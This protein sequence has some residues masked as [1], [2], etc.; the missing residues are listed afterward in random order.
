MSQ[1]YRVREG[2]VVQS[3]SGA[4]HTSGKVFVP[5]HGELEGQGHALEAVD[6]PCAD[7]PVLNMPS[8]TGRKR[9]KPKPEDGDGDS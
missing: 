1:W 5:T 8:G 9:R 7:V 3:D 6:A 4:A 2:F